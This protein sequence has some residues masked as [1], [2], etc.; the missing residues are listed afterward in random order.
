M[1]L[2]T[3]DGVAP[4]GQRLLRSSTVSSALT[5]S[6]PT[7]SNFGFTWARAETL[8]RRIVW[9]HGGIMA[10]V[11]TRLSIDPVTRTGV[12][13]LTNGSCPRAG[14]DIDEIEDRVL[15]TLTLP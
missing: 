11:C 10:G 3:S 2:W 5:L 1:I 12:A 15:R 8:S 9:G 7:V 6:R 13:I 4:N 14:S